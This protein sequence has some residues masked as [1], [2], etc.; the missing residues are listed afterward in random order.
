MCAR[1]GNI[2]TQLYVRLVVDGFLLFLAQP[3]ICMEY[4]RASQRRGF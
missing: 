2:S 1:I 4:I 3:P